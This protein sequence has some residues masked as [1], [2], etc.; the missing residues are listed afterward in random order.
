VTTRRLSTSFTTCFSES[1]LHEIEVEV[2]VNSGLPRFD[3]IGLPQHMIREGRDRIL[4]ALGHLG[5]EL[6]S[7]KILV[8]LNPGSLP[9]EGSHFDLPILYGILKSLGILPQRDE[10][11]FS[12]GELSLDGRVRSLPFGASHWLFAANLNA[13]YL[14]SANSNDEMN[15]LRP[16]LRSALVQLRSVSD[17]L[18][19]E[20]NPPSAPSRAQDQVI[21]Q[22]V[23]ELWLKEECPEWD[24]LRGCEEQFLIWI[25]SSLGRLHSLIQGPP[26]AGKSTWAY[27]SKNLQR[28]LPRRD[29]SLSWEM[30]KGGDALTFARRPFIAPHHTASR[31]SIIGGGSGTILPGALSRAHRG[32]LFL[33]EFAEFSRDIL[34]SLREPLEQKTIS[35]ARGS[36]QKTLACDTQIIGALNPCRCGGKGAS[37]GCNC[38]PRVDQ[39]YQT[40]ISI[41]LRERFHLK[42]WWKFVDQDPPIY[43]RAQNI[44]Q[45]FL[46]IDR[47]ENPDLSGIQIPR[48]QS[49]RTQQRFLETFVTWCRFHGVSKT[50]NTDLEKFKQLMEFLP[51]E[52]MR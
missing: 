30:N 26:G 42:F 15:S 10:K 40:R 8:S 14:L 34:E 39:A 28:P 13:R 32:C 5:I 3:I 44:K 27:A 4:A 7:Q 24:R 51:E 31:V 45:R 18:E 37:Q 36:L 29:W 19:I 22:R 49:P 1:E 12:W 46:E 21:D 43:C 11:I 52:K 35:I 33:D 41:P 2:M 47:A 38:L 50:S 20:K 48:F 6:P 17:I 25:L 9:K 16:F 23:Q